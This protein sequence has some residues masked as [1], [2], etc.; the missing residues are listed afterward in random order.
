[1]RNSILAGFSE[2]GMQAVVNEF[3]MK[4]LYHPTLFPVEQTNHLTWKAVENLAEVRQAADVVARGTSLREKP[5]PALT[6]ID[7]DLPKIAVKRSMDEDKLYESSSAIR[8]CAF[9]LLMT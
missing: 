9:F 2:I 6:R 8:A 7:G 4:E 3:D 1:M 5:R